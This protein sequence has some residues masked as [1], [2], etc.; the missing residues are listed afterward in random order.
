MATMS[1]AHARVI[2]AAQDRAVS[3]IN[4][5]RFLH[6]EYEYRLCYEGGFTCFISIERRQVGKRNFKWFHGYSAASCSSAEEA[7][8]GIMKIVEAGKPG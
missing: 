5:Y 3:K 2:L 8:E 6:G 4:G 1:Y 7:L